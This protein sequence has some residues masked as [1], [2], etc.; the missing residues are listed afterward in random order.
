MVYKR[1]CDANRASRY[2][3]E[4]M[5]NT[6]PNCRPTV[7]RL[8]IYIGLRLCD[9]FLKHFLHSGMMFASSIQK[10]QLLVLMTN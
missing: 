8:I 3:A 6:L 2:L 9:L 1:I 5:H 4:R 7:D 10:E